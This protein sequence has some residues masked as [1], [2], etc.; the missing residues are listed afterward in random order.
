MSVWRRTCAAAFAAVGLLGVSAQD[1]PDYA[2]EVMQAD[3]DFSAMA[4]QTSIAEAFA[5]YMDD[6]DGRLLRGR[7][8]P[9]QGREAIFAEFADYPPGLILHWEPSEGFC[10]SGG[11]FR[12]DLGLVLRTPGWR[13]GHT[14]VRPWKIRDCLAPQCG[15]AM[16]W[17]P[18]HGDERRLLRTAC[19]RRQYRQ[20]R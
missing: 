10:L 1:M 16:A 6:A 14:A 18:G 20:W 11:R 19:G 2:A 17:P 5:T 3:R 13:S 8:E 4:K 15:R 12:H 9:I 7:G